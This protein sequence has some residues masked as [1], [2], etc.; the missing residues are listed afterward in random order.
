VPQLLAS[1]CRSVH[2]EAPHC[3]KPLLQAKPHAEPLHVAVALAGVVHVAQVPPQLS[4]PVLHTQLVPEQVSLVPHATAA[5]QVPVEL[6]VSMSTP[7]HCVVPGTHPPSHAPLTHALLLHGTAAPHSPPEP[8]V[9]T[10]LPLH[11]VVVGAQ[12]PTH[13]PALHAPLVQGTAVPHWPL[14]PQVS[15]PLFTHCTVSGEQAPVQLPP[16]HT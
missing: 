9:S 11:C 7:L 3:A 2:A 6:H 5:P 14:L 13:A 8:Q 1:V 16:L 4:D 12:L 15:T 10:P